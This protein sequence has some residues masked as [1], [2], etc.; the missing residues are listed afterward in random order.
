MPV[1]SLFFMYKYDMTRTTESR[2]AFFFSCFGT[3]QV[4]K[5]A[6]GAGEEWTF[7]RYTVPSKMSMGEEEEEEEEESKRKE[8]KRSWHLCF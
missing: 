1:A 4:R 6:N 3:G 5:E 2:P 7:G 8:E